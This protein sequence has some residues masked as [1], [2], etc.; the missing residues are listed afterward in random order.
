VVLPTGRTH[1]IIECGAT[2]TRQ[3]AAAGRQQWR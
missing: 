1:R 2:R 3:P